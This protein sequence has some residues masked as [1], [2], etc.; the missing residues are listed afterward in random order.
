METGSLGLARGDSATAVVAPF[1]FRRRQLLLVQQVTASI[2]DLQVV[3]C[4]K[5]ERSFAIHYVADLRPTDGDTR[6]T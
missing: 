2:S 5:A 4:D 1:S 6:R 3:E